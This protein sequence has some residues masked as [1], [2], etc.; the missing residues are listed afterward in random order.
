MDQSKGGL[1]LPVQ[2][3][4]E[5]IKKFKK[6]KRW[7][8]VSARNQLAWRLEDMGWTVERV[9]AVKQPGGGY[10]RELRAAVVV[11]WPTQLAVD[12]A[13]S[14]PEQKSIER[15]AAT[16]GIRVMILVKAAQYKPWD[17]KRGEWHKVG[18][19]D[20]DRIDFVIGAQTKEPVAQTP[21]ELAKGFAE[22]QV[23]A[24]L[25]LGLVAAAWKEREPL[26]MHLNAGAARHLPTILNKQHGI[27][28]AAAKRAVQQLLDEG[29]IQR[30][31]H[32]YSKLSGLKNADMLSDTN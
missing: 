13:K 22:H 2:Q 19:A 9:K 8:I 16:P 20:L 27:H 23:K 29:K 15:L 28:P 10:K 21:T 17:D 31:K 30:K 25:V 32:G 14:R 7:G 6:G 4:L 26:S 12:F 1:P 11:S 18:V 5:A 24:E 3:L